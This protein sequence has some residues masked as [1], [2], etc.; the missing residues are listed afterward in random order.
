[1]TRGHLSTRVL[2]VSLIVLVWEKSGSLCLPK[3]TASFHD[4]CTRGCLQNHEAG[5]SERD[6]QGRP[7]LRGDRGCG[8]ELAACLSSPDS[9]CLTRTRCLRILEISREKDTLRFLSVNK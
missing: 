2:L 6:W 7:T 5:A 3:Q 9:E 1:M 4:F 8:H